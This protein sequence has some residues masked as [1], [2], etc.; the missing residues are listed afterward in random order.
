VE[1]KIISLLPQFATLYFLRSR[2]FPYLLIKSLGAWA[3]SH[4]GSC[5]CGS[6]DARFGVAALAIHTDV[7][8]MPLRPRSLKILISNKRIILRVG[9]SNYNCT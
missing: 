3:Q 8:D 6:L 7:A 1:Q 4:T 5:A 9:K 2:Q